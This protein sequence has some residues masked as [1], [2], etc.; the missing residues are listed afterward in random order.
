[1]KSNLYFNKALSKNHYY[2]KVIQKHQKKSFKQQEQR[3][4]KSLPLK[5]AQKQRKRIM[6]GRKG[7]IQNVEIALYDFINNVYFFNIQLS[8]NY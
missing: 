4:K 8:S 1:M 3:E 5:T 6:Q 7:N 2:N